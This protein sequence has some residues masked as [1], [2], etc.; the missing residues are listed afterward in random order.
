[1][2][3]WGTLEARVQGADL[4]ILGG[5]NDGIWPQL[6]PPDP[7]LNRQMRLQCGLLLPERRVGLAAHDFQ[8]AVAA[9]R[10]VLTR[11]LRDAEAQTVPSR[12]L[13]RLTNLLDG[14]PDQGG[15]A[16]LKTMR[17]RGNRWLE[18]AAA[19]DHP[20]A[21]EPPAARPAPRPP[22]AARPGELPVTGVTRLIRDPYEIYAK[23]I[24]R[25]RPLDP[26]HPDADARLRGTALHRVFEAFQRAEPPHDRA[27][28]LM[29]AETVLTAEVPWQAARRLW[30]ARLARVADWY[31]TW[32]AAQ[33][34][35]PVLIEDR[36][37]AELDGLDF[38]ITA[39]PDRIDRLPDG[40][41]HIIDYKTGAP[42]SKKQQQA[43]DK[44]LLLEAAMAERGAFPGIGPAQVARVS[45]VGLG[46]TPK[47]EE[48]VSEERVWDG[49]WADLHRLIAAYA[50]RSQG[51][52][53]RRAMYGERDESEYDHLSRFGEWAISDA[54]R[55]EDVG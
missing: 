42:P 5:L 7:W 55:P 37:A 23:Y 29:L 30:L 4:V 49:A 9:R 10:V 28:L 44:Q 45:Y 35:H 1:V 25:L 15:Q 19:L 12:W 33:E 41:L 36:G 2:M 21:P 51:Y 53:A 26:L 8:Q 24:L 31:L 54:P 16:A 18:L 40:R 50:Q 38:R 3:I 20:A 47:V 32:E 34:G 6:P 27:R 48:I 22:V 43:F 11:A 17:E 46:P 39:R 52:T 14:L 13:N